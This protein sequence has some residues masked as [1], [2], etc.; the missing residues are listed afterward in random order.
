MHRA[1]IPPPASE[2]EALRRECE[3]DL[4][5]WVAA[6]GAAMPIFHNH[7]EEVRWWLA[8]H[9]EEKRT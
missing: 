7:G 1:L 8:R 5:V 6:S 9:D 4:R 3:R 2:R